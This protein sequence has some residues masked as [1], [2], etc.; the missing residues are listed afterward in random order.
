MHSLARFDGVKSLVQP[1]L[2]IFM[3]YPTVYDGFLEKSVIMKALQ[4]DLHEFFVELAGTR[5]Y[6]FSM[7]PARRNLC[8]M[9]PKKFPYG[10]SFVPFSITVVLEL[11]TEHFRTLKLKTNN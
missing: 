8:L 7:N 5:F 2:K 6:L 10:S 3:Y 11:V 1:N 9:K 4:N